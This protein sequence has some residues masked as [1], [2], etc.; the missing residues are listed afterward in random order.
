MHSRYAPAVRLLSYC[1][2][3]LDLRWAH[4]WD[5]NSRRGS[6][7]ETMFGLG[8]ALIGSATALRK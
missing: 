3:V 7:R 6:R 2:M 5:C 8:E 4:I 1:E